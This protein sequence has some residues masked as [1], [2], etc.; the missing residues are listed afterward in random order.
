MIWLDSI[1]LQ[2]EK[3]CVNPIATFDGMT[4]EVDFV[5]P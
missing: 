5:T 1:N 2:F 3:R 4:E